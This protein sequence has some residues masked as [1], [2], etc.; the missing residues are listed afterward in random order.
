[1][2]TP[3]PTFTCSRCGT[4]NLVRARHSRVLRDGRLVAFCLLCQKSNV[5]PSTAA[6]P[7]AVR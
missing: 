2:P 3:L 6:R 4:R 5:L 1:M 7:L